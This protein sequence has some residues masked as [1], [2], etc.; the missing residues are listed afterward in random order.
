MPSARWEM[1]CPLLSTSWI[2]LRDCGWLRKAEPFLLT[3]LSGRTSSRKSG[4]L[5]MGDITECCV[6]GRL[7][8]A[9]YFGKK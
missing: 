7:K 1:I 5:L 4:R 2:Q 3:T 9:A 8:R 6:R